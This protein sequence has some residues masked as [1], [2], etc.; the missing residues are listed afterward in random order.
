MAA[1]DSGAIE[2][3][4]WRQGSVMGPALAARAFGVAPTGV[5]AG[6]G[7][8][9]IVTSHDCDVA[10]GQLDKEPYVEVLRA[11]VVPKLDKHQVAGRNPRMLGLEVER[12]GAA[13]VLAASVHDR[14]RLPR[15]WLVDE[16]PDWQIPGK[17]RRLVAEWL[18]KR[19][20]R[21]AFPTAFDQ[22]WRGTMKDWITLL[23]S[24]SEW[25]QGVYLRLSTLDELET[26][27]AYGVSLIVAA[28][29]EAKAKADW[30][31]RQNEIA[32]AVDGFWQQFG[33]GIA[34]VEVDVITTAELTL[35]DLELYQRFDA[36]WV[37]FADDTAQVTP[38]MDMRG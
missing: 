14:W 21:S 18:A 31:R 15:E 35:A 30:P 25:I 6:P 22:R 33:P 17:Q 8:W 29:K 2:A 37:S 1:F 27:E 7:D 26:T 36:D 12:D 38:A 5:T 3:H 23:T 4:G 32:T 9:L 11:A 34:F 10:N 20:I 19:Y 24:H 16:K 13:V 28:P